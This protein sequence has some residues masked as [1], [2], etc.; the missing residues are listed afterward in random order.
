MPLDP[1]EV[2]GEECGRAVRTEGAQSSGKLS[3]DKQEVSNLLSFFQVFQCF[4][5]LPLP[6]LLLSLI[7]MFPP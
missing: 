6:E 5:V 3:P 7:V 2:K 4:H 1:E